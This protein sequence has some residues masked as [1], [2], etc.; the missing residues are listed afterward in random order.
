MTK[1][2]ATLVVGVFMPCIAAAEPCSRSAFHLKDAAEL[3]HLLQHSNKQPVKIDS[4]CTPGDV[5]KPVVWISIEPFLIWG[6]D[7][8]S[9][10]MHWKVVRTYS[11]YDCSLT[12]DTSMP[13][14][15]GA[16]GIT[17][18]DDP[19]DQ[20]IEIPLTSPLHEH[21][22]KGHMKIIENV[23]EIE[24][25][26]FSRGWKVHGKS[27]LVTYSSVHVERI[28]CS[29]R[30]AR[31]PFDESTCKLGI[32]LAN[33]MFTR[34]LRWNSNAFRLPPEKGGIYT[35]PQWDITDFAA[36]RET[37]VVD[38]M[39]TNALVAVFKL[40]RDPHHVEFTIVFP[41]I[42]Y[43]V[44]SWASFFVDANAA[45]ARITLCVL[46]LLLALT[47][48]VHLHDLL[49]PVSYKVFI[50]DYVL[51]ITSLMALHLIQYFCL[52][53][54]IKLNKAWAAELKQKADKV[55]KKA[56]EPTQV[57][58]DR[59][60]EVNPPRARRTHQSIHDRAEGTSPPEAWTGVLKQSADEVEQNAPRP[61]PPLISRAAIWAEQRLDTCARLLSP[62]A[63]GVFSL[64]MFL[65]VDSFYD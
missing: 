31:A 54:A 13:L 1:C 38:E 19:E 14:F 45:P 60:M 41:L 2:S 22:W 11:Y 46:T 56:P 52:H 10:T 7:Q 50:F 37:R 57:C 18:I 9:M 27:G 28:K 20:V 59:V 47:L 39:S 62:L 63:F 6:L 40:K 61:T 29:M 33:G 53:Y 15:D 42:I 5:C 12:W 44:L 30:F 4:L 36:E 48:Y 51:G 32:L 55:E 21:Q 64:V 3:E 17:K 24:P 35:I 8:M 43:F 49:P 23:D 25:P 34:E 58:V 65:G 26:S 16:P